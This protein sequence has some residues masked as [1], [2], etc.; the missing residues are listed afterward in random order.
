MGGKTIIIEKLH[1]PHENGILRVWPTGFIERNAIYKIHI[2]RFSD[3]VL[4]ILM[5]KQKHELLL[6]GISKCPLSHLVSDSLK[7]QE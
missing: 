4:V 5:P 6:K 3:N 7:V 2:F 1:F